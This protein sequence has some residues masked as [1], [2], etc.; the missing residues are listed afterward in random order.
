MEIVLE[1]LVEAREEAQY[2]Q[3]E[4]NDMLEEIEKDPTILSEKDIERLLEE[5]SNN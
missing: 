3:K 4:I 2:T 1:T 5:I